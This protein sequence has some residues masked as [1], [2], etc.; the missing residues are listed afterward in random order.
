MISALIFL[1]WLFVV[2]AVQ[3][4]FFKQVTSFLEVGLILEAQNLRKFWCK[5]EVL[6]AYF[7]SPLDP[8]TITLC[9]E[10]C[11]SRHPNPAPD[12]HVC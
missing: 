3:T 5:I 6:A 7:L 2:L 10:D 11:G 4:F 1:L 9:C 12:V 8:L